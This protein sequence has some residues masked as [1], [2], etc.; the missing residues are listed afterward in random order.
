MNKYFLCAL[1]ALMLFLNTTTIL[2]ASTVT[3][4]VSISINSTM[5][6]TNTTTVT[7]A[8]TER[9]MNFTLNDISVTG[10]TL[11]GLTSA[12]DPL[13]YTATFTPTTGIASNN[14]TVSIS[15]KPT[16]TFY[17][18]VGG[19]AWNLAFD[20]SNMW[21][22]NYFSNK[23]DKVAYDGTVTTYTGTG[24]GP[25]GI[26]FDGT[27]MWTANV[28]GN[29]VT[30]IAPDGSM[31]NYGPLVSPMD[32]AFDG[33]NMW[34]ANGDA[35]VSKITALGVI[36]TYSGTGTN[37]SSIAFDGTNMWT[38][39]FNDDSVTKITP[40]GSMTTYT[41]T[42]GYPL[43]IAFDGTNMWTADYGGYSVT[44][45]SPTG[46]M[47]TYPGL[48][49]AGYGI[50]FD[51]TDLWVAN[52]VA[53]SKV[54]LSGQITNYTS[55]NILAA[56]GVAINTNNSSVWVANY[57]NS[58][59]SKIGF[60]SGVSNTFSVSRPG[61]G[62]SGVLVVPKSNNNKPLDFIIG[63]G[64]QKTNSNKLTLSFNA[65]SSTTA[66]YIVSLD[67]EFKNEVIHPYNKFTNKE[68]FIL[69]GK[70]GTYTVYLSYVSTAGVRSPLISHQILY[71]N[72]NTNAKKTTTK[73]SVKTVK[74]TNKS[75]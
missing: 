12:A 22:T 58:G 32:I 10:G 28:S 7:F 26:A 47:T 2:H 70:Y 13:V 62:W 31:T 48:E 3:S 73:T 34:T 4:N 67:P 53:V 61:S 33:T 1:I 42:G 17:G 43:D 57:N 38:A 69:P 60:G 41:G 40:A 25:R 37:P 72:K 36:T 29:N 9:P 46:V 75:N 19:G 56:T 45:I 71:Q 35:S 51:G 49:S 64:D 18:G 44:K 74:K 39:S 55:A 16:A 8:F 20:G 66:G 54:T 24:D 59:V 63:S 27:N 52:V 5:L 65:D 23:V 21:V 68:S 15:L 6:N 30:K 14:N 11:S 50:T